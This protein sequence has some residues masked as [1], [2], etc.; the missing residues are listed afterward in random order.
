ME[1]N[2]RDKVGIKHILRGTL[3]SDP[4]WIQLKTLE[5][6]EVSELI[7]IVRGGEAAKTPKPITQVLKNAA[8]VPLCVFH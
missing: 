7:K 2:A 3:P 8:M 1:T 6:E 4:V 5:G